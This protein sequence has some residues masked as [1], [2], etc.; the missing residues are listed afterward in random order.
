[1]SL[2]LAISSWFTYTYTTLIHTAPE[3][4]VW[5]YMPFVLLFELPLT[6]LV[7]LCILLYAWRRWRYPLIATTQYP[8]WSI[9]IT[10]YS[11]GKD[12]HKSIISVLEQNYP[13]FIQIIA[14]IDGAKTNQETYQSALALKKRYAKRV[15]RELI[16]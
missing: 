11:E 4:D 6:L 7:W 9:L 16:V 14:I 12:V 13:G 15:D 5:R 3:A 2:W 1:M 10:C 8:K